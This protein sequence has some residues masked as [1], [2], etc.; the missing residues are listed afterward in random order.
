[1]LLIA[2]TEPPRRRQLATTSGG[3]ERHGCDVVWTTATGEL[4][5]VQRKTLTDLW[6]SVR[7]GRLSREVAAMERLAFA[8]LVLEGRVRWSASGTLATAR[9]PLD[10]DQLWGIVLSA[11]R[12][13]IHV[14]HTD[15]LDD[16]AAAIG[17]IRRW[18]DQ[19]RHASLDARPRPAGPPGTRA[20][21]V[22]LLQGFPLIGPV[23][24]GHIVDHFSGVPS[25]GRARSRSSHRARRRAPSGRVRG[26]APST[27]LSARGRRRCRR[28]PCP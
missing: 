21:G 12:R 26:G 2:H 4:A 14:V 23:V 6:A 1:M 25:R 20:W 3:P 13:R 5:G 22:H 17:H 15:D 8:V 11:Q 16:T 10:R 18:H 28:E 19:V 27:A 7:D 24:A 9:A